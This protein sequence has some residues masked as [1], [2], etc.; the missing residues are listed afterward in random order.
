MAHMDS[1]H[2]LPQVPA[3]DVKKG[4]WRGLMRTVKS[5]GPVAITNHS[6]PEAVVLSAQEYERLVA[7]VSET[8]SK[9]SASLE[10]LRHR[11]DERLAALKQPDAGDRLRAISRSPAKLRGKVKAGSGY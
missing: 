7:R 5:A 4:G 1:I 10:V 8:E 2:D 11:F 9:T 3:S 6:E